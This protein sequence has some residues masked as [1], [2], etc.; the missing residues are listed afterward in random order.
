MLSACKKDKKVGSNDNKN[1]GPAKELNSWTLIGSGKNNVFYNDLE[2]YQ[3]F[4]SKVHRHS[5]GEIDVLFG[6][7]YKMPNYFGSGN[8]IFIDSDRWLLDKNRKMLRRFNR[9]NDYQSPEANIFDPIYE[10]SLGETYV[11]GWFFPI[12]IDV[13]GTGVGEVDIFKEEE[14]MTNS[15]ISPISKIGYKYGNVKEDNFIIK[16]NNSL[17]NIA[18][19]KNSQYNQYFV[20]STGKEYDTA[21]FVL[22]AV[23]PQTNPDDKYGNVREMHIM[24]TKKIHD[25]LPEWD[26]NF[27]WDYYQYK[28]NPDILYL[29]GRGETKLYVIQVDLNTFKFKLVKTYDNLPSNRYYYK[30]QTIYP[31]EDEE[32]TMILTA[33]TELLNPSYPFKA[34]LLKNGQVSNIQLPEFYPEIFKSAKSLYYEKGEMWLMVSNTD[35]ECFLYNK[36]Y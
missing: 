19:G 15:S 26:K 33:Q 29:M 16:T 22:S 8:G 2:Y 32:G 17:E 13:K 5:G 30:F 35:G 11:V 12:W 3:L 18:I 21:L 10:T 27:S 14:N 24:F 1:Q 9:S 4:L 20:V 31:I 25:I 34:M 6:T 36:K 23:S 28:N 7:Q